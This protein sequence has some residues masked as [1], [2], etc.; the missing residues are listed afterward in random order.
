MGKGGDR[1]TSD[2]GS[3]DRVKKSFPSKSL[4]LAPFFYISIS[5]YIAARCLLV[6]ALDWAVGT[7]W[8][9]EGEGEGA[10]GS[11]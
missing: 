8:A 10:R 3:D 7:F 6:A 1:H 5:I 9:G 11:K 2:S 4:V